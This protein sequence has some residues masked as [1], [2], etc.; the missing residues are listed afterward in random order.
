M[1][2]NGYLLGGSIIVLIMFFVHFFDMVKN[3]DDVSSGDWVVFLF[4]GFCAV[5]CM[6][7]AFGG[8]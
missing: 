6:G 3:P 4:L 1:E 8:A 7:L 5:C 2:I